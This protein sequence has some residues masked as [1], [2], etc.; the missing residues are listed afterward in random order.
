L[1][2]KLEKQD[3]ELVKTNMM[4][5]GV[6]IDNSIKANGVTF[7]ELTITTKTH[8]VAFFVADIE[9]SYNLILS[10]DWIHANQYGP[11]TLHQMMLQWIGN[12]IEQVHAD[13]SACIVVADAPILW[14]YETGTCLTGV[15][16]SDY[17]F[18]S[19]DRKGFIPVML[20]PMQN[21]LN[22]M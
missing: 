21:Q 19:L 10:R 12:D 15:D 1:Y 11:S 9:G 13:V 7:I 4:L 14:T 2:K 6:G 18:I 3:D 20:E 16:F 8:A 5:S 17:K 22:P